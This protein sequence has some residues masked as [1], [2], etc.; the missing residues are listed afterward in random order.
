MN[1]WFLEYFFGIVCLSLKISNRI[2]KTL[3]TIKFSKLMGLSWWNNY[4]TKVKNRLLKRCYNNYQFLIV[5]WQ[6]GK[7]WFTSKLVLNT[8]FYKSSHFRYKTSNRYGIRQ[9]TSYFRILMV[10]VCIQA[11]V[12]IDDTR[13][14]VFSIIAGSVL[15]TVR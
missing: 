3:N 8:F 9:I 12:A 4:V 2:D 10:N 15:V 5:V 14:E 7:T 13:Q 6:S 1:N 11:T